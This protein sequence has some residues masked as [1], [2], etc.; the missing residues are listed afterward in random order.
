M[1][2]IQSIAH[3]CDE[4]GSSSC[5]YCKIVRGDKIPYGE[6]YGGYDPGRLS[7]PAALVIVERRIREKDG[8]VVFRVIYS[9][10]FRISKEEKM[11][12]KRNGTLGD[13]YTRFTLKVADIYSKL[14]FRKLL[15]DSTSLGNPIVSHLLEL[16]LPAEGLTLTVKTKEELIANLKILMEQ[17]LLGIPNDTEL[18]AHLNCIIFE[19]NR[20]GNYMFDHLKGT[21]DDLAHALALA[22]W[23]AGRRKQ[24]I[25]VI[26]TF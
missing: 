15:A 7:D 6:L 4:D 18:L 26:N 11:E 25:M 21:H 13:V 10:A 1:P 5:E 19:R 8:K 22:V 17:K 14:R 24:P 12:E 20:T 3:I 23:G 2:L 9:K 16:E